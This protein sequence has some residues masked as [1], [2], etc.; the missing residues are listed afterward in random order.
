MFFADGNYLYSRFKIN[1][2]F[3][4]QMFLLM[5]KNFILDQHTS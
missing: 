4:S 2:V 5:T 1:V 3:I